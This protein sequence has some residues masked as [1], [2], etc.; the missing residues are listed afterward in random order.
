MFWK[1]S[2]LPASLSARLSAWYAGSAF[3]LLLVATGFLYWVLLTSFDREDD[4][5]LTEK[6]DTLIALLRAHDFCTVEWEVEGESTKRPGVEVLS[7]VLDAA[8]RL[9]VESAGMSAEIPA[10][11]LPASGGTEYRGRSGRVFRVLSRSAAGTREDYRVQVALEVTFEKHLLA[12]Y[13]GRL[14]TVL[15]IGLLVCV[16]VG[17]TMARRGLR[18]VAEIARTMRRIRSTTLNERIDLSGLPSELNAL[19]ATFNEMLDRLEDAFGRLARFSSDIAHELRT[20]VNN[21]RGEVEVALARARSPEEYRDALGS[22]L[23]ECLRLSRL[24]DS[25]LFLARAE[26][27]GTQIRREPLEIGPELRTV[28]EFYEAAAHRPASPW[29]P[30]RPQAWWPSSIA[31]CSSGRSGTWWRTPW[32]TPRRAAASNWKP[33]ARKAACWSPSRTPAAAFRPNI[34]LTSSTASTAWILPAA[35]RRAAPAWAS[36]SSKASPRCTA[37]R[38]LLRAAPAMARA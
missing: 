26:N 6:A 3:L 1:P 20:P 15:G 27:P 18:P 32:R 33:A 37:A 2:S 29:R 34:C 7:R 5:Y 14:W 28:R 17:H 35:R 24:I 38:P 22:S 25:L 36:P 21:L 16:L 10:A 12:G 19:A 8:G 13:R 23:E 31:P 4:Q 11:A 30:A 9:V